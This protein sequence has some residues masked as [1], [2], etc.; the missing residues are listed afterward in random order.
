MLG[1]AAARAPEPPGDDLDAFV[2]RVVEPHRAPAEPIEKER[3]VRRVDQEIAVR[4][5]AVLRDSAFRSVEAAWRGLDFLLRRV[6]T[7]ED[8]SVEVLD[9]TKEEIA[10]D[11]QSV[12]DLADS[13]LHA[14]LVGPSGDEPEI[15]SGSAIAGLYEF[16]PTIEDVALLA[17]LGRVAA[18]AGGPFLGAASALLFGAESFA[19]PP[20]PRRWERARGTPSEELWT[21]LRQMP[22]ARHLGLAAPRFLLRLP[23]GERTDPT[24]HFDFEEIEG[25]PGND[26]YVWGNPSLLCLAH[27]DSPGVVTGLPLHAYD[28]DGETRLQPAAETVLPA[29]VAEAMLERGV[30]PVIALPNRDVLRVARLQSIADPPTRLAGGA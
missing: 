15:A 24:E 2:R 9:A 16:G 14:L 17:R 21:A 18:A 11:L 4:M 12:P 5:R 28:K 25:E 27:L 29:S 20:D 8:L 1:A 3:L 6:E 10:R 22:E 26:S 30:I 19:D 13:G 23:Y 7:G